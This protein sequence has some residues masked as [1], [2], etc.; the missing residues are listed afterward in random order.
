M[1]R[2]IDGSAFCPSADV[3]IFVGDVRQVQATP[4][5][6]FNIALLVRTVFGRLHVLGHCRVAGE[7]AVD[8]FLCL[9]RGD[10]QIIGQ[11]ILTHAVNQ[12]KVNGFGI[13]TLLAADVFRLNVKHFGGGAS[14]HVFAFV[15]RID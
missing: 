13:A 11:T 3:A 1:H 10:F 9:S 12:T 6:G 5:D 7:I 8:E 14:V 2:C 15:K 4:H